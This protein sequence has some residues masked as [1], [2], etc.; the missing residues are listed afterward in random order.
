[1]NL[2]KQLKQKSHPLSK[3][4]ETLLK[5]EG[6]QYAISLDLKMGYYHIRLR[7]STSNSCNIIP[8]WGNNRYKC[9]PM[10]VTN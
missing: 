2:N 6:F 4:N 9:I 8:P 7:K 1:M 3:I 5:L 10:G